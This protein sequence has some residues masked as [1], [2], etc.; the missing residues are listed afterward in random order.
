MEGELPDDMS[1][2]PSLEEL[3]LIGNNFVRI[4]S[5]ISRLSKL[6]SLRLGNCKKLQSLPDLPSRLEYLG[7]DG[8]ASL[9]TLP[10]LFEECA[11]SK[12]LSL[13]FMNCS[14]LTDYQGN[15]SMGLTWLKY[16]L[17]F[18]LESGHQVSI[19]L[20][21]SLHRP[22]FFYIFLLCVK[23]FVLCIEIGYD[24]GAGSSSLLVFYLFSRK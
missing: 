15:I 20:P 13:I 18:L 8:C 10:N 3:D 2:F 22:R 16:Y 7:V 9:G 11:R 6:K 14:E 24:F 19:S 21:L 23:I 17:H 4:P 5:S 1:C 12:F